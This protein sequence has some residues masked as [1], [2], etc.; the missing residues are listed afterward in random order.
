MGHFLVMSKQILK[1]TVSR[2]LNNQPSSL[3]MTNPHLTY[4]LA[5]ITCLQLL[6]DH[7]AYVARFLRLIGNSVDLS[8]FLRVQDREIAYTHAQMLDF[9]SEIAMFFQQRGSPYTKME[10][11]YKVKPGVAH[12]PLQKLFVAPTEIDPQELNEELME[13]LKNFVEKTRFLK[14]GFNVARELRRIEDGGLDFQ[15]FVPVKMINIV[16][17]KAR[18]TTL[19]TKMIQPEFLAPCEELRLAARSSN[20]EELYRIKM[21][22]AV[23]LFDATIVLDPIFSTPWMIMDRKPRGGEMLSGTRRVSVPADQARPTASG[24]A[25]ARTVRERSGSVEFIPIP[26]PS[27]RAEYVPRVGT[28]PREVPAQPEEYVPRGGAVPRAEY[29]P[30]N[31]PEKYQ[32]PSPKRSRGP[33]YD[34]GRGRRDGG[35]NREPKETDKEDGLR[36]RIRTLMQK[37]EENSSKLS[38]QAE[39]IYDQ[40]NKMDEQHLQLEETNLK[41]EDQSSKLQYQSLQLEQHSVLLKLVHT[42]VKTVEFMV[43]CL[44]NEQN[45]QMPTPTIP[46]QEDG[47]P[48]K[49]EEEEELLSLGDGESK[50]EREELLQ[51][52]DD[53]E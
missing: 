36:G 40:G 13:T 7:L 35:R 32:P 50:Q 29:V 10:Q 16:L 1:N 4:S 34:S 25:P 37:I 26:G 47:P 49:P 31:S 6:R 18:F 42:S 39:Q 44:V 11:L 24:T 21:K 5:V 14:C 8:S 23:K 48:A 46:A 27:S 51:N 12:R 2:I 20:I 30:R 3:K 38:E 43:S 17:N 28:V 52:W 9:I 22:D 15:N 19:V 41:L 45:A 33:H 53:D